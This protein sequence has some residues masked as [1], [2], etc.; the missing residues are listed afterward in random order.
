MLSSSPLPQSK[1]A[2]HAR[3]GSFL[4]KRSNSAPRRTRDSIR[5]HANRRQFTFVEGIQN[6]GVVD[7]VCSERGGGR[8]AF[9]NCPASNIAVRISVALRCRLL[10]PALTTT[11]TN[12]PDTPARRETLEQRRMTPNFLPLCS[13]GRS[14]RATKAAISHCSPEIAATTRLVGEAGWIRTL[15]T[16]YEL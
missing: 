2:S 15:G 14:K 6:G 12:R 9:G 4:L 3:L 16:V 7:H 1:L 5:T 13:V 11:L 8:D 10:C